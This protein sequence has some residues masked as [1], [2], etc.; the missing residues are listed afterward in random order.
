MTTGAPTRIPRVSVGLGAVGTTEFL[1]SSGEFLSLHPSR[2]LVGME[3][4]LLDVIETAGR[5]F[6]SHRVRKST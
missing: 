6:L 1:S 2:M 5:T 4:D 3:W